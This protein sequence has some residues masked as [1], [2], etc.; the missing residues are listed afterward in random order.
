MSGEFCLIGFEQVE[1]VLYLHRVVDNCPI[2]QP[3]FVS[4][5]GW[6]FQL[7]LVRADDVAQHPRGI[8]EPVLTKFAQ[9]FD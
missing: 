8:G 7:Y 6:I 5:S 3:N 2:A 1:N 4:I 9:T